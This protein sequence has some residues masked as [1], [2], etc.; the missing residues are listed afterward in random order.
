VLCRYAL[1]LDAKVDAADTSSEAYFKS[2]GEGK[3]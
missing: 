3:T 1:Q 2:Q